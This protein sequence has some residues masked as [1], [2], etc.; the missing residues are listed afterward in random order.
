MSEAITSAQDLRR[1]YRRVFDPYEWE[2]ADA[3]DRR[4]VIADLRKF[5]NYDREFN[6][7]LGTPDLGLQLAVQEGRRAVVLRIFRAIKTSR[8]EEREEPAQPYQ[9]K[10]E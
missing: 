6:V 4:A 10:T 9:A 8:E 5:G 3:A 7:Q 1:A 2:T